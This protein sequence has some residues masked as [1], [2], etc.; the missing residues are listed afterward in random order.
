MHQAQ[1]E[2][3]RANLTTASQNLAAKT[4]AEWGDEKTVTRLFGITHTPLFNLRKAGKIRSLST[5]YDGATYG[6]RLY[7]LQSIRDFLAAQEQSQNVNKEG[8]A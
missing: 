1:A 8:A 3:R 2:P 4:D 6:K 7:H 5:A